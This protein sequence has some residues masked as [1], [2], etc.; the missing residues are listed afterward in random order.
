MIGTLLVL[1]TVVALAVTAV[2]VTRALRSGDR[3]AA[4]RSRLA[5]RLSVTA[6]VFAAAI[7]VLWTTFPDEA[8]GPLLLLLAWPVVAAALPV[9]AASR[10]RV[11]MPLAWLGGLSL[12]VHV[13]LFGLSFGLT[14][15]LPAVLLIGAAIALSRDVALSGV[16]GDPTGRPG[17]T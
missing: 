15:L 9:I 7:G 14:Y 3:S 11:A 12:L 2:T 8:A 5:Q 6:L 17:R 10:P 1:V 13:A 4:Q 16:A